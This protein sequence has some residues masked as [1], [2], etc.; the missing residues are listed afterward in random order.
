MEPCLWLKGYLPPVGFEPRTI[1]AAGQC[2]QEILASVTDTLIL[3]VLLFFFQF[4]CS[5]L[6]VSMEEM[7]PLCKIT[8]FCT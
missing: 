5:F 1:R 8:R 3:Y 4:I 2:Y 7:S 6:S